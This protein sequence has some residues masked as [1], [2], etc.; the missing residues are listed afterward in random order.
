M[1][2][3]RDVVRR[4]WHLTLVAFASR[5]NGILCFNLIF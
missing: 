5:Y 2:G 3:V 1:R 4:E